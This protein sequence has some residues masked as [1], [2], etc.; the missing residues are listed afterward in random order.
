MAHLQLSRTL[1]ASRFA[2][3]DY[4]TNPENLP[5]L[6]RDTIAV[7]VLS[8]DVSLKRGSELHF[9]MT[10][11][12]LAQSVRFQ[13]EELL[14]GSRLTYRQVEGLFAGWMHTTRFEDVGDGATLVTDIVQYQVPFG[15]LGHLVNDVLVKA[16][17]EKILDRRLQRAE[18][19]FADVS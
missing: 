15:L 2:A 14:R 12:G 18:G 17:L 3:Y 7:E 11:F 6:L 10:R 4:L 5:E 8:P 19:H 1:T 9:R 16:D 13:I